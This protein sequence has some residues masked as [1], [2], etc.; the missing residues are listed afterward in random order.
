MS[1]EEA[2]HVFDQ[3]FRTKSRE[4]K[5]LNPYSNGIGLSISKQICQGLD[6]DINVTTQLGQ[7]SVFTF[8][9]TVEFDNSYRYLEEKVPV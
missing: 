7:G 3:F 6:G 8:T 2:E 1:D 4:S 9:M 5:N